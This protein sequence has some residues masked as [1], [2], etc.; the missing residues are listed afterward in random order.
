MSAQA[1]SLFLLQQ[2]RK[3]G[4]SNTQV[5]QQAGISRQTWYNLLNSGI[6]ETKI[7][8]LIRVAEVLEV[9]PLQLLDVYFGGRVSGLAA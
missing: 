9:R 3:Q 7:S 2:M 1:L 5:A 4:L 6:K 8:T